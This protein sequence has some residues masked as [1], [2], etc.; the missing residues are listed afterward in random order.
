MSSPPMATKGSSIGDA[1]AAS[2]TIGGVS[3]TKLTADAATW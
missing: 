3:G 2:S 1:A